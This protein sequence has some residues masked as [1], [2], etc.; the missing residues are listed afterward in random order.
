MAQRF[1]LKRFQL[2]RD[3]LPMAEQIVINP[4]NSTVGFS[5]S[6]NGILARRAVA[7]A[8]IIH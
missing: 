8:G 3:P 7:V 6:E 1:D 4:G 2:M 5:V